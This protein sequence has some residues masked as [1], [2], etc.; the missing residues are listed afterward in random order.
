MF[1]IKQGH[2]T[3]LFPGSGSD[4]ITFYMDFHKKPVTT[5]IPVRSIELNEPEKTKY[6]TPACDLETIRN[7]Y[8]QNK[9]SKILP[10]IH[11]VRVPFRFGKC[12]VLIDGHHRYEGARRARHLYI[13][14]V[15]LHHTDIEY[16][17]LIFSTSSHK[18][19]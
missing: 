10:P 19:K 4:S 2:K 5:R 3:I 8:L 6:C 15:I 16:S 13:D 18:G 1:P 14:A 9:Q 11:V 17:P 12:Y 7:I